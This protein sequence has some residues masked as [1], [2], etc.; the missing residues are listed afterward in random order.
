MILEK[1]YNFGFVP[2]N[3]AI[4]ALIDKKRDKVQGFLNKAGRDIDGGKAS[5]EYDNADSQKQLADLRAK[6]EQLA[7][8]LSST[9]NSFNAHIDEMEKSMDAMEKNGVTH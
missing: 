5:P 9:L 7:R 8:A 2:H 4:Q 1:G 3:D 6:N